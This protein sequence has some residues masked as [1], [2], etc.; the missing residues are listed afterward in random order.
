MCGI[1]GV[2]SRSDAVER[3][4]LERMAARLRHRGPEDAGY[5][6]RGGV[7][8]AHT[9]LSI[10]DLAG[11][12]QPFRSDDGELALV[13]NGEIY[14]FVELRTE[15]ELRGH[16]FRS[17]SDCEVIL[18]AY[19]E[20][21][22][23]AVSRLHGMFAFALHDARTKR[24]VLARDRLG[25]KP[26]FYVRSGHQFVFASEL[27]ALLPALHRSPEVDPTAVVQWLHAGVSDGGLL[28]DVQ[29]VR[30]GCVVTVDEQL[31][32]DERRY[33]DLAHVET[34][35]GTEDEALEA[36]EALFTDVMREHVRSDVPYGLFLS[37]G[38]DSGSLAHML[39]EKQGTSLHSFSI[40]FRGSTRR[41][42]L[43][44]AER[45]SRHFG[46]HHHR[47]EVSPGE[48]ERRVVEA[49]W[50]TDGLVQDPA[51]LPTLMLAEEASRYLKVVFTGEGG[52]EAFAGYGRYRVTSPGRRL[53]ALLDRAGGGLSRH[54]PW[55][56]EARRSCLGAALRERWPLRREPVRDAWSETHPS[57]GH[58]RRR[59][60]VDVRTALADGLLVKVDR[61]LMAHGIEGRV[62]FLDHRVVEFGFSLPDGLKIRGRQR[63]YLLRKWAGRSSLPADH[64]QASKR[65]FHAPTG[66][67]LAGGVFDDLARHLPESRAIREWFR[68]EGV[69]VLLRR[70][71]ERGDAREQLWS[72]LLFALWH[73]LFI[74]GVGHPEQGARIVD[75][76]ANS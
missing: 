8:L 59:Q 66:D 51:M 18:H 62:P 43:N 33:W 38:V 12:H 42:E 15:L 54:S 2:L 55:T 6:V 64:V 68:P 36:F 67:V 23:E 35:Q 50:A 60:F 75:V 74:D 11:G 45:I 37:G 71:A 52:D 1:A 20:Y 49:V 56:R 3:E 29:Q 41:N 69:R 47:L 7:G 22:P 46:T 16:R 10:I 40:G 27:K 14:N 76:L 48:L 65:G 31:E 26:L 21:G 9:R 24:L 72:L 63:K 44:A 70:H 58:L 57:W 19:A 61:A 13:A 30:P 39:S 4:T 53:V 28:E 32:V 5:H 17:R 34:F 25:I 73:R